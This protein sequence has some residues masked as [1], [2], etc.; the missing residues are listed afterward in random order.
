M[1]TF[2][3]TVFIGFMEQNQPYLLKPFSIPSWLTFFILLALSLPRLISNLARQWGNELDRF[4]YGLQWELGA[5]GLR[6]GLMSFSVICPA[7][8]FVYI[9]G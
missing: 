9:P 1:T 4:S 2:N 6:L 7:R 3:T 5:L 8:L